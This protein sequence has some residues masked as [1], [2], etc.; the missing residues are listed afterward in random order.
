[1]VLLDSLQPLDQFKVNNIPGY[2][3][4]KALNDKSE[5]NNDYCL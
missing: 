2:N 3:Y 4:L 1:M 5:K